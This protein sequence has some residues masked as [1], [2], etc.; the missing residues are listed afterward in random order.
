MLSKFIKPCLIGGA[1]AAG[2][3][4][5][6]LAVDLAFSPDCQVFSAI[7]VAN[8]NTGIT[9]RKN[10]NSAANRA[11]TATVFQI[12]TAQNIVI[13]AGTASCFFT[14]AGNDSYCFLARSAGTIANINAVE[15]VNNFG[16]PACQ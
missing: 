7:N 8:P 10:P 4:S 12:G 2:W 3:S 9:F 11:A 5:Q 14:T 13:Q 1:L 16:L 15:G 6:V